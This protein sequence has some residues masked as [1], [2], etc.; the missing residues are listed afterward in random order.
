MQACMQ[1]SEAYEIF[2]RFVPRLLDRSSSGAVY[3]ISSSRNLVAQAAGW[4]ELENQRE[5]FAPDQC[6]ALRCGRPYFADDSGTGNCHHVHLAGPSLCVP[7]VAHGEA[8]GVLN[9]VAPREVLSL[10]GRRVLELVGE[11]LALALANLQ[12]RE[13]LRSQSIRDPLTGLFNRRYLEETFAREV[14][15]AHRSGQSLGVI[16]FD[17]DHFKRL[18]DTSGHD[19]GDAVLREIGRFVQKNFRA[20]DVSCRYGGEEF[21]ILVPDSELEQVERRAQRL[22]EAIKQLGFSHQG[23]PLGTVTVS[24]GVAACPGHGDSPE[25]LLAAVDAALYR[26]KNAGRDR[27]VVADAR[28]S[29]PMVTVPPPPS[30]GSGILG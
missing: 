29:T 2:T 24:M 12:L 1:L 17:V 4:G 22:R 8:T 20:A 11:Q 9:V 26:A 25:I 6:W 30:K 19:A 10:N 3:L 13:R 27:V 23:L 14:A 5:T 16:M 18:N 28:H 21:V 15:R 7:L